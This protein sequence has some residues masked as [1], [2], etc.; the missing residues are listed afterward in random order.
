MAR[1]RKEEKA[2]RT[3]ALVLGLALSTGQQ[4]KVTLY[5]MEAASFRE[6]LF[7]PRST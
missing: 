4:V 5:P 1:G 3:I 6:A 2:S 7:P